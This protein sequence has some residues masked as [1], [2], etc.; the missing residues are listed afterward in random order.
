MDKRVQRTL[1]NLGERYAAMTHDLQWDTTYQPQDKVFPFDKYEAIQ[2]RDWSQWSDPFRLTTDAYWKYQGDK[3]KR[4][5]SVIEAYA[6]NNGQFGISDARYVNALKLILQAIAPLKYTL[7][8]GLAHAGRQL[9]GDALRF[10]TQ[11]QAVDNLRHFQNETHAASVFNKYFNGLHSTPALFDSAWYLAPA[12]SFAEDAATA[13][14]FEL[15]VAVSFSFESLISDLLFVP[16]MSGAAHNGDLAIGQAGFSSQSDAARHKAMGIEC[17]KFLLQQDQANLPIIQ[18]WID[19][20]FWRSFRLM[21]MVAMMQDYML[22]K[23]LMSW[24]E[25]WQMVVEKPVTA[26]FAE[27]APYGLKTPDSWAQACDSK[28]HLSHQAWNAAYT[29]GDANAFHTWVPETEELNWLDKKYPDSCESWYRPRLAHY[30]QR[31]A[32]GRRYFNRSL[33]MQCQVCQ[34]PMIFTELGQPRW[35]AYRE[36]QHDGESFHFCSDPCATVFDREPEKYRQ[37][38]LSSHEILKGHRYAEAADISQAAT[39]PMQAALAGCKAQ[40]GVDNGEF[41]GSEDATHFADWG[42]GQDM[43]EAQL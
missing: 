34:Q 14:P 16:Y 41:R 29:Y 35:I 21:P 38:L 27:L 13:G 12:K 22:P 18:A 25:S 6:Q 39:D 42:G 36:T 28:D 17:V 2:V 37:A 4:L 15:L 26:L 5:Y 8:R 1:L 30:A 20:W 10:A 23:R 40:L 31:Q 32:S 24:K 19:K 9:R 43:K 3:E 7:H 33:P 11:M